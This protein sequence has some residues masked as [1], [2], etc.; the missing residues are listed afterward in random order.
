PRSCIPPIG[1]RDSS[2]QSRS[3]TGCSVA[4]WT[5]SDSGGLGWAPADAASGPGADGTDAGGSDGDG[6]C[7]LWNGS[8]STGGPLSPAAS[9]VGASEVTDAVSGSHTISSDAVP[10]PA[11]RASPLPAVFAPAPGGAT[12]R[13]WT[14]AG[15][16]P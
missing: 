3:G 13:P 8:G 14:R 11:T 2:D 6:P 16:I 12:S 7:G 15:S 5:V 10:T 4:V 1:R 9:G